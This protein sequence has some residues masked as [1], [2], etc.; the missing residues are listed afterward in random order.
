MLEAVMA[1]ALVV[2]AL[3]YVNASFAIRAHDSQ[4]GLRAMSSDVLNV[5]QYRASSLEHPGLGFALSSPARWRDSS[6]SLG[7]DLSRLL[8]DGV[9]YCMETPYGGLGQKP[10]GG[11]K[12]YSRPFV[13]CGGDGK[14]LDC[15]LI[16]WRP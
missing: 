2:A 11:A 10:P 7:D 4:D 1:T 12:I 5:L 15:K 8:P 14:M 3:A 6:A 9:Y 13:V 16:L